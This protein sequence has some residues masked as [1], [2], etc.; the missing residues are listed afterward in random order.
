[1]AQTEYA[2]IRVIFFDWG[3]TVMKEFPE[4][5]GPMATW[6]RV[7][8]IPGAEAAL[9][10]LKSRAVLAIATNASFSD[11]TQVRAALRRVHLEG[12]FDAVFT[13][14]E[15]KDKKPSP[16]YFRKALHRLGFAPAEAAMVG[17]DYLADV[18]GAKAAGMLAVWYNPREMACPKPIP[19]HDIEINNMD[20]LPDA[21]MGK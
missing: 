4:Y 14:R 15:L 10:R 3:G 18:A 17:D 7:E 11:E 16:K 2:M 13:A 6:P 12:Y 1:M 8:I 5:E 9:A 19:L 21:L 20:E